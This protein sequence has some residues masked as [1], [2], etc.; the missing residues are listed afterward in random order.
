MNFEF[1]LA[2]IQ[3]VFYSEKIW[4]NKILYTLHTSHNR[5]NKLLNNALY[6]MAWIGPYKL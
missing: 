3:R 5:V 4:M 2:E 1:G 6:L